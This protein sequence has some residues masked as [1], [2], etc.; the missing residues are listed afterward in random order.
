MRQQIVQTALLTATTVIA[1][2][3][4]RTRDI[5]TTAEEEI[6]RLENEQV[7]AR[8][9]RDFAA[10]DRIWADEFVFTLAGFVQI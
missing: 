9:R 5:V 4:M 8:L 3:Q 1:A 7:D 2:A 6:R 10:L